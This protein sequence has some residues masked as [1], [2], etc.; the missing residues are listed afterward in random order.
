[1]GDRRHPSLV[2]HADREG[3][4]KPRAHGVTRVALDVG[5]HDVVHPV[6]E[7][8]A[9]ALHLCGRGAT[10]GRREG[11]VTHEDGLGR[12]VLTIRLKA[13]LHRADEALDLARDVVDVEPRGVEGAVRHARPHQIGQRHHAS[14][15]RDLR[16]L[17]DERDGARAQDGAVAALVERERGL[18]K[19]GLL[20]RGAGRQEP[21]AYPRHQVVIRDVIAAD[22]DHALAATEANP[23]LS[24]GD[25]LGRR[26]AR[27]VHAGV[28]AT[29]A[30][31]LC[32]SSVPHADELEHI[33]AIKAVLG[34]G[35]R[36]SRLVDRHVVAR[37]GRGEDHAR[38]VAHG[39]GERHTDGH[40]LARA[41]GPV[42]RY[43]RDVGV[44]EG[45]KTRGEG[46]LAGSIETRDHAVLDTVVA[47]QVEVS[48]LTREL[49]HLINRVD[50]DEVR[51]AVRALHQAGDLLRGHGL[52][53]PLGHGVDQR[54][55]GEQGLKPALVEGVL[56]SWKSDGRAR[57]HHVALDRPGD[58]PA[59]RAGRRGRRGARGPRDGRL[60]GG[61][62]VGLDSLSGGQ[63]LPD[64]HA[65]AG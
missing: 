21:A 28:R 35:G 4:L 19:I 47:G 46:E 9:K 34:I 29:G 16:A 60:S 3:V 64:G 31:L 63:E 24:D 25:R 12:H 48:D 44:F 11:L 20:G 58:V 45:L 49:E 30:D 7:G 54:A 26:G 17:Q 51:G 38:L 59:G 10:A 15:L 18:L 52:S 39:L 62:L 1:M 22:D 65:Q 5:D 6:A 40:L 23:V 61:G 2:E 8:G 37:E 53:M 43:Q 41:R 57:A 50:G 32:E 27:R 56:E 55:S 33:A 42:A 36:A 14:A 13:V